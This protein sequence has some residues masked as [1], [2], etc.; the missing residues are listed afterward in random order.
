MRFYSIAWN[1]AKTVG[2]ICKEHQLAYE[3]RKGALNSLGIVTGD[4]VEAWADMT[5]DD[6]CTI[7]HVVLND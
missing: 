6:N 5:V 7:E 4:F 2:V 3:L 1:E